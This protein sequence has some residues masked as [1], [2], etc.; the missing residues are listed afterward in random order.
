MSSRTSQ[1]P[2]GMGSYALRDS[3]EVF[4][5]V[6]QCQRGGLF[7]GHVWPP[8]PVF[9]RFESYIFLRCSARGFQYRVPAAPYQSLLS[10]SL[11]RQTSDPG[12]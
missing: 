7:P 8:F 9:L 1:I 6:L 11:S 10:M 5:R 12:P 2:E 4:R 3:P